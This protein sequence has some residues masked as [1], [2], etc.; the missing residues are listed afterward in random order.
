MT[1]MTLKPNLM[2]TDVNRSVAFYA[3]LLGL[4]FQAGMPVDTTLSPAEATPAIPLQWAMVGRGE[5]GLMF[6]SRA[7]L[8]E[9]VGL[10]GDAEPGGSAMLYF[11]GGDLDARCAVIREQAEVVAELRTTFYGM[12]EIWF[13]DPDGYLVVL[14]EK[15]GG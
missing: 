11:E 2:V 13:R 5:A 9:D 12:R 4:K 3:D 7:S 15:A 1:T 6:Q 8:V 10:F 14:A